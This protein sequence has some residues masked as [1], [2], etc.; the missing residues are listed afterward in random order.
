MNLLQISQLCA[1]FWF[2]IKNSKHYENLPF[3]I[4]E[5]IVDTALSNNPKLLLAQQMLIDE[6]INYYSNSTY[7]SDFILKNEWNCD[8]TLKKIVKTCGLEFKYILH[9]NA[10]TRIMR[11]ENNQYRLF[12][13]LGLGPNCQFFE[14]K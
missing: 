2:P 13:K 1:D 4:L 3:E 12:I 5:K 8:K 14:K 9:D 7:D 10:R 6:C 11:N